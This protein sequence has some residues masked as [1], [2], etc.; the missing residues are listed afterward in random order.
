MTAEHEHTLHEAVGGPDALRRLSGT[1]HGAVLTS[2]GEPDRQ[3]R[4]GLGT[5]HGPGRAGP[6][7]ALGGVGRARL[8]S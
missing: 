4:L 8:I 3:G 1:F 6:R 7:S 5:G 2:A